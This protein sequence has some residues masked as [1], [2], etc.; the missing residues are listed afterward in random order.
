MS[1]IQVRTSFNGLSSN[2]LNYLAG[3]TQWRV[4]KRHTMDTI[5]EQPTKNVVQ[6]R[7]D[8]M[9]R[10]EKKK[11]PAKGRKKGEKRV[12]RAISAYW[13]WLNTTITQATAWYFKA[14]AF[15]EK[16]WPERE[17]WSIRKIRRNVT[18]MVIRRQ[19]RTQFSESSLQDF[20]CDNSPEARK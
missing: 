12:G 9:M 10:K 19:I 14:D 3:K 2:V 18:E 11:V 13:G 7:L 20:F 6:S 8:A 5:L 15:F 4:V 17:S 16:K 1:S